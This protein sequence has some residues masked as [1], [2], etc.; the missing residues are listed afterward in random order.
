LS[1]GLPL[2]SNVPE[3]GDAPIR[4]IA[5]IGAREDRPSRDRV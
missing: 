4:V 5:R 3:E 1:L 2:E